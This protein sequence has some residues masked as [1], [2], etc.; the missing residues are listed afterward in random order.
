MNA[1][2]LVIPILAIA[3]LTQNSFGEK[4]TITELPGDF[5]GSF[6]KRPWPGKVQVHRITS[7]AAFGQK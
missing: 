1:N 2:F 5:K 3:V 4:T 7:P 6:G